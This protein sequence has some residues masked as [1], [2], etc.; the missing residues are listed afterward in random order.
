MV[1]ETRA[2]ME[3]GIIGS[4][5]SYAASRLDAQRSVAGWA[6]EATGGLSYLQFIRALVGRM[7][8]DWEGVKQDLETIRC[9][10]RMIGRA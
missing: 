2:S 7:E 3:A 10:W 8:N 9:A 5:H 6:S 1:L 4:G